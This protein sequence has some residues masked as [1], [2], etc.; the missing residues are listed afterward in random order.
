MNDHKSTHA[1]AH[2]AAKADEA[3]KA[4]EKA[5]EGSLDTG[6]NLLTQNA[7]FLR[8]SAALDPADEKAKTETKQPTR[9]ETESA[10]AQ[11][12]AWTVP[13]P[14]AQD[15]RYTLA[16]RGELVRQLG[17]LLASLPEDKKDS[18]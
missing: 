1:P 12:N 2:A 13:T 11:A 16:G 5:V 3:P 7:A 9:K 4:K 10:I 15:V 14:H 6:Y 17:N 18:K 8:E